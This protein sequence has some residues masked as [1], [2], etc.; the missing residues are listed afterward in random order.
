MDSLNNKHKKTQITN[1]NQF[2]EVL[3][4]KQLDNVQED[5]KLYLQDMRRICKNINSNPFDKEKCCFWKGYITNLK[6]K[7]KGTYI[8]FYFKKKKLALHRLLYENY[9]ESLSSNYYLKYT[10]PNKGICCNVNH[11]K[12]FKYKKKKNII[13]D[14][15]IEEKKT[16]KNNGIIQFW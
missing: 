13:I 5:R 7:N 16:N 1:G 3:I 8:N 4:K 12:K 2:L 14:T 15:K 6:K 11:L 10:C 9:V